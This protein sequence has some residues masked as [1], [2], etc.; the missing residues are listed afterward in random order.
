MKRIVGRA[1]APLALLAIAGLAFAAPAGA[2]TAQPAG[3]CT[4]GLCSET[5]NQTHNQVG[6]AKDWCSGNNGPC[7]GTA[8]GVL[9]YN[10]TTPSGQDWDAFF[11]AADCTYSGIKHSYGDSF[12]IT[13]GANGKWVQVHND[14]HYYIK[15]ITC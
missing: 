2:S 8:Y 3:G 5:T 10:Q 13:A 12:S 6:T 7:S 9:N 15:K 1:L 11:V 14:E 4:L